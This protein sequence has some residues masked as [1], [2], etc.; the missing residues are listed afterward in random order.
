MRRRIHRLDAGGR[1]LLWDN[2]VDTTGKLLRE[3]PSSC[4]YPWISQ[5]DTTSFQLQMDD[6]NRLRMIDAGTNGQSIMTMRSGL[7]Q[8]HGSIEC[9]ITRLG[10]PA[11]PAGVHTLQP[12]LHLRHYSVAPRDYVQAR[13]ELSSTLS[14]FNMCCENGVVI[15]SPVTQVLTQDQSYRMKVTLRG[16]VSHLYVDDV[17]IG[18]FEGALIN[19]GSGVRRGILGQRPVDLDPFAVRM[20][21]W[22]AT[23]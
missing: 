8:R 11:T 16:S 15:G 21:N 17:L 2:F 1:N 3:H 13:Y 18:R 6:S 7:R 23:R 14:R 19:K 20:D 4:G 10:T 5:S 22:M 9:T 12:L